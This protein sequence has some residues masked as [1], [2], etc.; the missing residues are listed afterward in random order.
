VTLR[1]NLITGGAYAEREQFASVSGRTSFEE[2]PP[3]T[4]RPGG[5]LFGVL[6]RWNRASTSVLFF[7]ERCPR[8]PA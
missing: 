3:S 7:H 2:T 5:S 6:R 8:N 1:H 4:E